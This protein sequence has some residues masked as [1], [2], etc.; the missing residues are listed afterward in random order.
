MT[1]EYVEMLRNALD[2]LIAE[3]V[4]GTGDNGAPEL[5]IDH[6]PWLAAVKARNTPTPAIPAAPLRPMSEAPVNA[7]LLEALKAALRWIDAVPSG[8]QLP[9]MPGFDRDEVDAAIQAAEVK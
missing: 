9:A 3:C 4:V 7:Q 2:D 6:A 5:K 1:Q 8:T